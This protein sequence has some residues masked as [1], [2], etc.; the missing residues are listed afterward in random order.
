MRIDLPDSGMILISGKWEGSEVSSGSGKSSILMAM[1]YALDICDLPATDLKNWDSKKMFVELGLTDGTNNY[2]ATR[3]PKLSLVINGV[4]Y[5][6]MAKGAKEKLQEILKTDLELVKDL[7]YRE[8]RT[9]GKFINS[10]DAQKKEFLSQLLQLDKFETLY[11]AYYKEQTDLTSSLSYSEGQIQTMKSMMSESDNVSDAEMKVA[12]DAVEAARLRL[13]SGGSEVLQGLQKDLQVA[14]VELQKFTTA[15]NQLKMAQFENASLRTSITQ[16]KQQLETMKANICPTCS[17]EWH[18]NQQKA[19]GVEKYLADSLKRFESNIH[20]IKNAQLMVDNLPAVRQAVA[21]IQMKIGQCS[22]PIRDAQA[23]F[24]SAQAV[25]AGLQNKK[26]R[27]K[28]T[29]R[30]IELRKLEVDLKKERMLVLNHCVN[31]LGR[32]GFLGS[33][34]DEILKEIEGK[35]NDMIGFLPNVSH[36]TVSLSSTTVTKTKGTAKKEISTKIYKNT[37]EVS[38]K[39]LSGGQQCSLELCADL[40]YAEA[41]RSRSGSPL[42]WIALDEAMEGFGVEEK[43]AAL[44]MIRQK[45][46]GLVFIIDHAT[47][48]KEGFAKTI[49]VRYNGRDSY[50]LE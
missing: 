34:F 33:I 13:N 46:R 27:Y 7:T 17:Q 21:D 29:Y 24:S 26:K 32:N 49:E 6:G 25:A 14:Q 3:D 48:I 42:N 5:E 35:V 23:A 30:D 44:N 43:Q 12:D 40:A 19:E 20:L 1:A 10:T 38:F 45:V 16:T 8:Q 15:E 9:R 28:D 2:I 39:S 22:A 11:D 31:I 50:V 47:E 36:L 41:I 37:Q 18:N 4:P